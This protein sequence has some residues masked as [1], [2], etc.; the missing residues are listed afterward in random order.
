MVEQAAERL[1]AEVMENRTFQQLLMLFHDQLPG[2][3]FC[4]KGGTICR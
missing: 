1:A 2:D 3:R 4:T